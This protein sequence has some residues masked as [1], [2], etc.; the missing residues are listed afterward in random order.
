M[1]DHEF[2]HPSNCGSCKPYFPQ[3]VTNKKKHKSRT[4]LPSK[5]WIYTVS[6]QPTMGRYREAA[7]FNF[8]LTPNAH[9]R[10][11][12][13]CHH[14]GANVPNR[15]QPSQP[16]ITGTCREHHSKMMQAVCY[17]YT[18]VALINRSC[19][20]RSW[21]TQQHA[22]QGVVRTRASKW[23]SVATLIHAAAQ[24]MCVRQVLW[25]AGQEL[26]HMTNQNLR[27]TRWKGRP[28]PFPGLTHCKPADSSGGLITHRYKKWK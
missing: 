16:I 6:E 2:C 22:M 8:I 28:P 3:N 13:H 5:I 27:F 1:F 20:N 19:Y 25:C 26:A 10:Y 4:F 11:I 12:V 18:N 23:G 14:N 17:T 21:N 24:T 7:H 9:P 15:W